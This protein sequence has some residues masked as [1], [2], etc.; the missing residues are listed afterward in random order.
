M[1]MH[2]APDCPSCGNRPRLVAVTPRLGP[3]PELLTFR[4]RDCNEVFTSPNE[5]EASPIPEDQPV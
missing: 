4:C 5:I 2:A 3:Y 1:D